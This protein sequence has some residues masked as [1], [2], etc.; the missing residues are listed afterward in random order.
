MPTIIRLG[1]LVLCLFG[2]FVGASVFFEGDLIFALCG[3]SCGFN[4]TLV[5]LFGADL[6]EL[7]LSAVWFLGA[8]VAG[9]L[10]VQRSKD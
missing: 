5:A 3:K 4:R 1:L 10:A 2:I 6:A 7:M 9:F 8:A